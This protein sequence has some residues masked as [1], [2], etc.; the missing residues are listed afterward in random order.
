MQ[1]AWTVVRAWMSLGELH[2][3]PCL[4]APVPLAV[5]SQQPTASPLL[6]LPPLVQVRVYN[7]AEQALAK[8]L[9]GGSGIITSMAVHPSGRCSLLWEGPYATGFGAPR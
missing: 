3:T 8:K 1:A 5:P 9:V 7:L 2:C 6:G 4:Y